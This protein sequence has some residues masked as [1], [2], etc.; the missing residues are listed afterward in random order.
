MNEYVLSV[1]FK[2]RYVVKTILT[3]SSKETV[4]NLMKYCTR[5]ECKT[6]S[7]FPD[8]YMTPLRMLIKDMPGKN[9]WSELVFIIVSSVFIFSYGEDIFRQV[10]HKLR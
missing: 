4:L 8:S 1:I 3:E 2:S 6:K 9:A 10:C 7:I 5:K